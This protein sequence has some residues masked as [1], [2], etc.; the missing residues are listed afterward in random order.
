MGLK[1]QKINKSISYFTSLYLY[2]FNVMKK[3]ISY[4]FLSLLLLSCTNEN[5]LDDNSI[6][7]PIIFTPDIHVFLIGLDGWGGYSIPKA[8]MPNVKYLMEEGAYTLKKRAVSPSASGPNW[9]SIFMG[10][11]VE[12]HG[13]TQWNSFTPEIPSQYIGSHGIC[14]TIYTLLNEQRP[15][16][17]TGLFYEWEG[18]K[19]YVDTLSIKHIE[20]YPLY[21]VYNNHTLLNKAAINYIINK[22]PF[23]CA[24]IYEEPDYSGHYDGHNTDAYYDTCK[25]MDESIGSIITSIKEA[26]LYENSIVIVTSDHGGINNGH[27]GISLMEMETPF[28]ICGHRIKRMGEFE[29][30]MMQYDVA[31]II[32]FIFGLNTPQSWI[33]RKF[34]WLF[35]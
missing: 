22:K 26:G 19:Y 2:C 12:Q 23:F 6:E 33:G 11:S 7:N 25:E 21:E 29:Q 9:A 32:A 30:T 28:I 5:E 35:Y 3:Y 16:M 8:D 34:E 20:H 1:E 4:I 27:G 10:V 13:Y 24:I 14:P 18:M 17:E 31:S 15:N